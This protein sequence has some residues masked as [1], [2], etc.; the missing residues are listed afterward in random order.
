LFFAVSIT[1]KTELES[2]HAATLENQPAPGEKAVGG[3][4]QVPSTSTWGI[5][6]DAEDENP[7]DS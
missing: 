5:N 4:L 1:G 7:E 3:T 6:S 2:E